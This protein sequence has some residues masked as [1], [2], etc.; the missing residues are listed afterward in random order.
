MIIIMILIIMILI[1]TIIIM[2]IITC[3]AGDG[4]RVEI[5]NPEDHILQQSKLA[6]LK[7]DLRKIYELLCPYVVVFLK[8]RR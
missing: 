8:S 2:M 3:L 4:K 5:R 6:F 1:I 7:T